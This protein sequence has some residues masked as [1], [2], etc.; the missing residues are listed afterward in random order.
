VRRRHLILGLASTAVTA[1]CLGTPPAQ[2][3]PTLPLPTSPPSIPPP[4]VPAPPV[5]VP[6]RTPSPSPPPS[7]SPSPSPLPITLKRPGLLAVE[8]D[9]RIVVVDPDDGRSARVLVNG[10]DNAAPRWSPDGRVL[11]FARGQGPVVELLTIAATNGPLR[12]LTANRR[13]ERGASWAPSADRLI[14]VLPHTSDPRAFDD[15]AEPEE[16]WLLDIATGIERKLADGFDPDLSPDGRSVVYATNGQRDASGPR[17]N[18]LR[19]VDVE[20]GADRPLLAVADLPTDLLP[21]FGLP[22]K[23]ATTRLRAPSWSPDGRS[24]VASADGHSSMAQTFDAGGQGLRPWALAFDG[25]VGRAR[26]SPDGTRLAVESRPAT[27]VSVVVLVDLASR[28]E[29][30]IG[31]PEAGFQAAEPAWSPDARRIALIASALP[32]PADTAQPPTLRVYGQDGTMQVQLLAEPGLARPDWA[33][34][35]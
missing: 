17:G 4:A 19:I 8:R 13:P 3:S 14:Y 10:P 12:R 5:V 32:G 11:L 34:A 7:P 29:R 30:S 26:W 25:G 24:L 23:P 31:G 28:Q 22:F 16:V 1:A 35:P 20:G 18:A 21:S 2:P 6:G 33:P 9:G 27:G 15:P